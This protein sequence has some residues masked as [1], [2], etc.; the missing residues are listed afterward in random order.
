MIGAKKTSWILKKD[1][2]HMTYLNFFFKYLLLKSHFIV[3]RENT[4]Y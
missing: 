4:Y 1:N 3:F 2:I